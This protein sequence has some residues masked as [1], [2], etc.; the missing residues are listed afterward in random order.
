M[1]KKT[2]YRV[3]VY[4]DGRWWMIR[5]PALDGHVDAEGVKLAGEAITQARRYADIE[6]EA[7]D[8]IALV[9]DVA[10]STIELDVHHDYDVDG[11]NIGEMAADAIALKE[12]A[13][14]LEQEALRKRRHI[15][16]VLSKKG[17]PVRDIGE[18]LGVTYQRAAQLTSEAAR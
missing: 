17:V 16:G 4:R 10:P 13:A 2:R 11:D 18:I 15:A 1:T 12:R 6:T 3:D 5:V 9:A 7:R 8:F 14:A